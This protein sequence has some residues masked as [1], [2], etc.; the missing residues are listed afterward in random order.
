MTQELSSSDNATDTSI[1]LPVF[2]DGYPQVFTID[3]FQIEEPV[4]Y[5][6]ETLQ[7]PLGLLI[8]KHGPLDWP[9]H[10]FPYQRDGVEA[11][12]TRASL[13][14]ADDMGLGKTLQAIAAIRV[15]AHQ[16]HLERALVV[17]P[18]SLVIQWRKAFRQ[19]APELRL[20]TVEG[21]VSERAW[22]WQSQAHVFLVSY[23]TLRQDITDSP[24]S[25]PRRH[26]W[27][28]V[29]LDE[30]QK[31]KN[32][33]A[34]VSH[35]IKTLPRRKAWALTGTP[36]ENRVDELASILEFTRPLEPDG[37]VIHVYPGY[38]MQELHL[39]LQ[40]RRKKAEV[41][42]QLPPKL[43]STVPLSLSRPQRTAYDRAEHDGILDLKG[44]GDAVRIENVLELIIRLKQICN[45]APSDDKSA[46][47][48]D[49]RDR[50]N[51]LV[52]EGH[53]A[54]I[55]SQFID[56][57][58]GVM[59]VARLLADFRPLVYT[60]QLDSRER[61]QVIERFKTDPGRSVLVLSLRAGG[62]GLNLQEA[63]YV[64]H[65]DRWWNPAV[66]TQAEDRAHR[67]GQSYPVNVYRYLCVDTI[68][69]RIE[70]ILEEKRQLFDDIIDD[71]SFNLASRLTE[72][73]LYALF[74][75]KP[76]KKA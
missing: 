56:D 55:Y 44:K 34:D 5:F 28:I 18:A 6:S 69:E 40:L 76:P 22:Q 1:A 65:F 73:E 64:F 47:M 32:R 35:R 48:D 30:A 23:E 42:P 9:F 60:G 67:I 74:G 24:L 26:R 58:F 59:H 38:K 16:N 8:D 21:P 14:L 37:Q 70:N 53:K 49:L 43:V 31:I 75:L 12:V 11:L 52:A 33:D 72:K 57:Q 39:H 4:S 68:E 61:S 66:E 54:I 45:F 29:V 36:L 2:L 15:L 46:K 51:T 71:V 13:L 27:D 63:S 20:L 17:S 62:L 19:I 3:S 7:P 50:L 10:L 25:P 41:L